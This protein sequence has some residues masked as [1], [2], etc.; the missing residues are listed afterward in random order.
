[1]LFI[2]SN[3]KVG[4][5][6]CIQPRIDLNSQ[7]NFYDVLTLYHTRIFPTQSTTLHT[8]NTFYIYFHH[9]PPSAEQQRSS[10]KN[11]SISRLLLGNGQQM[12]HIGCRISSS[13]GDSIPPGGTD[14]KL[15]IMAVISA[16][17]G[18]GGEKGKLDI[19]L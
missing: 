14:T 6:L 18:G 3:F 5:W 11:C 17:G 19:K 15:R 9:V 16:G 1:M 12:N 10:L 2:I 7:Y 8:N 4:I 13:G